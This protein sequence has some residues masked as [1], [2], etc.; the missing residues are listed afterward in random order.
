MAFCAVCPIITWSPTSLS[1]REEQGKVRE[2]EGRWK[3]R[4]TKGE[5]MRKKLPKASS[6]A[7]WSKGISVAHFWTCRDDQATLLYI[8][9][10][11]TAA[12]SKTGTLESATPKNNQPHITM[13]HVW[14]AVRAPC[15][16]LSTP[17]LKTLLR[18]GS[19]MDRQG[20]NICLHPSRPCR[21]LLPLLCKPRRI[22]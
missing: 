2:G 6:D 20:E 3:M 17:T 16:H 11:C 18:I 19:E 9:Y 21:R 1:Y 4:E 8:I 7:I 15:G 13:R 12:S 14:K 10:V 5:R 22:W